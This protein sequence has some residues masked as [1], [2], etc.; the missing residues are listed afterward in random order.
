MYL[1]ILYQKQI[2]KELKKKWTE[3]DLPIFS[4]TS[5]LCGVRILFMQEDF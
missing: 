5:S 2:L 1:P 3:I 4:V